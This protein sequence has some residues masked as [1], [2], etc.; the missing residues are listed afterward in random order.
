MKSITIK[1]IQE[2]IKLGR[3]KTL[4]D[5]IALT[6]N[7]VNKKGPDYDLSDAELLQLLKDTINQAPPP[8]H[9]VDLSKF[10]T[11]KDAI[12][13]TNKYHDNNIGKYD[14]PANCIW[15]PLRNK[16]HNSGA[17]ITI[18]DVQYIDNNPSFK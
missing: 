16:L 8:K 13:S 5:A 14:S 6:T 12:M 15:T 3:V 10:T 7:M 18:D 1:M 11:L 9:L 4:Q 17:I 2:N